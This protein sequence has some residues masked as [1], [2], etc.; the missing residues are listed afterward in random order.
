VLVEAVKDVLGPWASKQ[1]CLNV[2]ERRCDPASFSTERAYSRLRRVKA[3]VDP[4]DVIRS[5]HPIQPAR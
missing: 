3:R 4:G 1:M 2:A 5:N